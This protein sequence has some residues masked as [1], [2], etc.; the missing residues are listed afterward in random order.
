MAVTSFLTLIAAGIAAYFAGR[1]AHWTKQQATSSDAQAKTAEHQ[2]AVAQRSI[3]ANDA[4]AVEQRDDL[5]RAERRQAESRLDSLAPAL[6]VVATRYG[7]RS[8]EGGGTGTPVSDRA[9]LEWGRDFLVELS[10]EIVIDNV[11][12]HLAFVSIHGQ[13]Y[14]EI[15]AADASWFLLAPRREAARSMAPKDPHIGSSTRWRHRCPRN[16]AYSSLHRCRRPRPQYPR[17]TS[18]AA[19]LPILRTGWLPPHHRPPTCTRPGPHVRGGHRAPHISAARRITAR[20]ARLTH[21]HYGLRSAGR[22][23]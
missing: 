13:G 5:V 20:V 7:V 16:M 19:R 9:V 6:R 18:S 15:R 2:L 14:D 1:A 23:G 22:V 11:S 3:D 10:A 4:R 12:G 17:H 8:L 21:Q